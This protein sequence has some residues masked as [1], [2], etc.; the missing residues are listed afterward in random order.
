MGAGLRQLQDESTC[1]IAAGG[2]GWRLRRISAVDMALF[3]RPA[4]LILP[5]AALARTDTRPPPKDDAELVARLEEFAGEQKRQAQMLGEADVRRLRETDAALICASVTHYRALPGEGEWEPCQLHTGDEWDD[6]TG[7]TPLSALTPGV[8]SEIGQLA[9][10]FQIG[11]EAA[12]RLLGA[13]LDR[14]ALALA[15]G[16][17]GEA[18]RREAL[19]TPPGA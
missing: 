1:E 10:Q 2:H 19:D 18:V 7:L 12:V 16:S 3:E 4:L 15:R 14:A 17:S 8:Q 5:A 11:G 13:F 9:Y 6:A